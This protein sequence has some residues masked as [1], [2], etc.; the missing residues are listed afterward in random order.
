[1]AAKDKVILRNAGVYLARDKTGTF[2]ST[3]LTAAAAAGAG[4]LTVASI[5]NFATSDWI[6]VGSGETLELVQVHISTAPSGNTITLNTNL[7]KAHLSGEAVVEQQIYDLGPVTNDQGAV[8]SYKGES[9]NVNVADN[10]LAHAVLNGFVSAEAN[11]TFPNVSLYSFAA[12]TAT[13]LAKIVGAATLASP[14]Q[15]A[16]DGTDFAGD[17]NMSM[18]I[19]GKLFDT[20]DLVAYLFGVDGDYTKISLALSRGKLAGLPARFIAAAGGAFD[21]SVPAFAAD[22]TNKPTKGKVFDSLVEAG[23]FS[24]ETVSPANTTVTGGGAAGASTCTVAAITNISAGDWLRFGSGNTMEIWQ[25][26]SAVTLTVT[27]RGAFLRAQAVGTVVKEQRLTD[28]AGIDENGATLNLGGNVT[29][30]KSALSRTPIGARPETVEASFNL[31][32]IETTLANLALS[33]GVPQSAVSGGRLTVSGANLLSAV[34]LNGL[35]LRGTLLDATNWVAMGWGVT[36]DAAVPTDIAFNNAGKPNT[37][38]VAAK[39]SS[40]LV[41][42]NY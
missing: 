32:V 16:T 35:Y 19:A 34:D 5:T 18:I 25:V 20:S 13:L 2:G 31:P 26:D 27:I 4:T 15:L 22:V 41:L 11:F 37:I 23:W 9:T 36:I 29:V 21:T 40:G 8:V 17:S 33:L 1:M 42:L 39:P 12:A 38:E 6:R 3:T 30:M 14:L 24:D 7:R 10:R 28:F